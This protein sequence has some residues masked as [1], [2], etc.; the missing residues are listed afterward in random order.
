MVGTITS[1]V[2]AHHFKFSSLISSQA[3]HLGGAKEE[4]LLR[5]GHLT[6]SFVGVKPVTK[7]ARNQVIRS[8]FPLLHGSLL[9]FGI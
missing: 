3:K 1:Y 4:N 8:L 6:F 7:T 5:S 2:L 9:Q